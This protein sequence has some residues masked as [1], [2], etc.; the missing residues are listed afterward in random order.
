MKKLNKL[1]AILVAMAM[2]LSLTAISAFAVDEAS[3]T[4]KAA[5]FKISKT[6]KMPEGTKTPASDFYFNIQLKD[7]QNQSSEGARTFEDNTQKVHFNANQATTA[8]TNDVYVTGDITGLFDGFTTP[9]KYVYK[10]VEVTTEPTTQAELNEKYTYDTTEYELRLYVDKDGK[11]TFTLLKKDPT[12]NEF[13][14][15]TTQEPGEEGGERT[16]VASFE[17][18]YVKT[19]ATNPDGKEDPAQSNDDKAFSFE[20]KVTEDATHMFDNNKFKF[21]VDVEAPSINSLDFT[22]ANGKKSYSYKIVK[23]GATQAEIDAVEA[24][25]VTINSETLKGSA[26]P[27]LKTGER[28]V[29]IDLDVGAKVSVKE[30]TYSDFEQKAKLNAGTETDAT[31]AT[32]ASIEQDVDKNLVVTN[33]SL[34]ETTPE[35]ILISNLPYIALALIAI[36][37]LV[38]YVVVRRRNAD[39]A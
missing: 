37:G 16:A 15:T 6:L 33:K 27:E 30:D 2:V 8:G 18:T 31:V 34:K 21:T 32:A 12:T 36:G 9:G 4:Q 5:N 19:A 25:P 1:F 29:F 23:I 13:E 35:G 28:L 26:T 17:N 7:D 11:Q 24:V 14:K 3:E 39:E 10:I 20:K 22:N 38:A